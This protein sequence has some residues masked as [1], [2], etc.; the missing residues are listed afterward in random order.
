MRYFRDRSRISFTQSR[1]RRAEHPKT[2]KIKI[3]NSL[4]I[5]FLM[6]TK[7]RKFFDGEPQHIYQ[8]TIGGFNIFYDPEDFLVFYTVFSSSAGKFNVNVLQ[9]CLMY[10]HIHVLLEA[11]NR[12]EMSD[13]V[14]HYTSVFVK[15]SNR[16]SG[17]KGP[18]FEKAYGSASKRGDKKLRTTIAYI[19]NNPVEKGLC[20]R[21]EEYRWNF[22]AYAASPNP[23]SGGGG[24]GGPSR[25][26]RKLMKEVE[27]CCENGWYLKYRQIGRMFGMLDEAEKELLADHIVTT[28]SQFDYQKVIASFGTYGSMLV[29]VDSF[30]GSEYDVKETYYPHSDTVY[31]ELAEYV[32][33]AEGC[34]CARAVTVLPMEKKLT[35]WQNLRRNTYATDLQIKKFL[36]IF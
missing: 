27:L 12:K 35:L 18:L 7:K 5:R 26:L 1:V 4:E 13:F 36:H 34:E 28:Y 9:L 15:E 31:A 21:A 2:A 29:A 24:R 20:R 22:L 30:T 16:A 32:R 6:R 19:F 14:C 8:R 17:R 3:I 11:G 33:T 23:F 25:Q 10:D